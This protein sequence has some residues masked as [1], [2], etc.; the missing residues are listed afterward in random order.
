MCR[1][2]AT[3]INELQRL[4]HTL[5]EIINGKGETICYITKVDPRSPMEGR[6]EFPDDLF[7]FQ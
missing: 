2:F 7:A 3:E 5:L 1:Y 6:F 4:N